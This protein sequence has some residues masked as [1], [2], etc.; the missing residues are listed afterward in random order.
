MRQDQYIGL[1]WSCVIV[2]IK[3]LAWGTTTLFTPTSCTLCTSVMLSFGEA[4]PVAKIIFASAKFP[5]LWLFPEALALDYPTPESLAFLLLIL[6][7]VSGIQCRHPN[8]MAQ[9]STRFHRLLRGNNIDFISMPPVHTE[10]AETLRFQQRS[11]HPKSCNQSRWF[12]TF[13]LIMN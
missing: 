3:E 6:I 12:V 13:L 1:S 10:T 5:S 11:T 2:H 4:C 9:S 8:A 7:L